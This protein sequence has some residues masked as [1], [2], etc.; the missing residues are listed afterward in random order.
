LVASSILAPG[1]NFEAAVL[2]AASLCLVMEVAED[3]RAE[4]VLIMV[5]SASTH[6]AGELSKLRQLNKLPWT[7]ADFGHTCS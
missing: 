1:T 3:S 5:T 4:R 7:G 2:A 6:L